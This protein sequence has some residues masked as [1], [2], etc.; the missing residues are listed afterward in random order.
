MISG[1]EDVLDNPENDEEEVTVGEPF[2]RRVGGETEVR[3]V[4]VFLVRALSSLIEAS[5]LLSPG[6]GV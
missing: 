1:I 4:A 6:N 2:V 5:R 3:M